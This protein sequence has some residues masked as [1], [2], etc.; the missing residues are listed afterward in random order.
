MPNPK[1]HPPNSRSDA[2]LSAFVPRG[3]ATVEVKAPPAPHMFTFLLLQDFSMLAFSAAIEPLRIANQLS[4]KELFRWETRSVDGAAV[5]CS[6]GTKVVADRAMAEDCA[7]QTVFVVSGIEPEKNTSD[8]A[9]SW[10]RSL[11]R[12]GR[13]VGGLCTG[14]YTLAR[15]GILEGQEFTLHWE[16]IDSFREQYQPLEPQDRIYCIGSRIMTCAGGASATEMMV[17]LIRQSF[18][19]ALADEVLNMCLQPAARPGHTRQ[20]ASTAALVAS[21]N[22]RLAEIIATLQET[23]EDEIHFSDLAERFNISLRQIERLFKTYLDMTPNE[24]LCDLRLQKARS[25]LSETNCSVMEVA[26]ACGFNSAGHFSKSFKKRFG[27][28]PARFNYSAG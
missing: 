13:T 8:P 21:R 27:V 9:A 26:T 10:I 14:A 24:Y 4:L 25:L 22:R 5:R 12:K 2:A 15:A 7:S 23:Y 17:G 1:S 28:T 20:K 11:W 19:A 6:N 16:N 3:I 18:G